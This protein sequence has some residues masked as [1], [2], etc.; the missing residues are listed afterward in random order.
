[1]PHEQETQDNLSIRNY[2][3]MTKTLI[4]IAHKSKYSERVITV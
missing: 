2:I 1:M 3:A 4:E